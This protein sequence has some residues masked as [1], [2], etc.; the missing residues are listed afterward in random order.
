MGETVRDVGWSLS[1]VLRR[2]LLGHVFLIGACTVLGVVASFVWIT[3][4]PATYR[5][6]T[7]LVTGTYSLPTDVGLEEALDGAGPLGLE[8][9]AETQARI[10]SSPAVVTRAATALG[11]DPAGAAS[12]RASVTAT[13][14]TDNVF[15][16][17]AAGPSPSAAVE[18]ANAVAQ[19][20]LGYRQDRAEDKLGTLAQDART[21]QE[22]GEEQAAALQPQIDAAVADGDQVLASTLTA[23]QQELQRAAQAESARRSA[24][25]SAQASFGGGGTIVRPA[26][27]E[28]VAGGRSPLRSVLVGA[29]GG[30]LIGIALALFVERLRQ[31]VR[32]VP[33]LEAVLGDVVVLERP[34]RPSG[35]EASVAARQLESRVHGGEAVVLAPTREG[36]G[37][38]VDMAA[39][40][41]RAG[42]A[43]LHRRRTESGRV[44]AIPAITASTGL[45]SLFQGL[46]RRSERSTVLVVVVAGRDTAEDLR[47]TSRALRHGGITLSGAVLVHRRGLLHRVPW[48]RREP[49]SPPPAQDTA[50]TEHDALRPVDAPESAEPPGG[51]SA[52]RPALRH[53]VWHRTDDDRRAIP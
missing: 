26:D 42:M 31:P 34:R 41:L 15:T 16:I 11:L 37:T 7:E 51:S 36:D 33:D 5:A 44:R 20:Y 49:S 46:D 29:L 27:A 45:G 18:R 19:A 21:S 39:A 48:S 14:D 17:T 53:P 9:P 13:P 50:P 25:E 23:R 35:E 47:R 32:D 1:D 10:I 3:V 43:D 52:A 28:A 30:M 22:S 40:W 38:T 4:T 2:V 12:L 8:L 24:L 6:D